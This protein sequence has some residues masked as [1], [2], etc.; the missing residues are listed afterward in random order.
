M[1][2]TKVFDTDKEK[3]RHECFMSYFK[4]YNSNN[5]NALHDAFKW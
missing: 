2:E 5:A 3:K 1:V 4:G